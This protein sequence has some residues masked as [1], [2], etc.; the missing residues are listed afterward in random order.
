MEAAIR[1]NYSL[2]ATY[3]AK[4]G[5][6][7]AVCLPLTILAGYL[8]R[9]WL[10]QGPTVV[11]SG[12]EGASFPNVISMATCSCM[13]NQCPCS[14]STVLHCN[15]GFK[16]FHLIALIMGVGSKSPKY[17]EGFFAIVPSCAHSLHKA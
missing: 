11:G 5:N 13:G 17:S 12:G 6:A 16:C 2:D 7:Q 1:P 9:A 4:D 8:S 3:I 15:K 10:K 14:S